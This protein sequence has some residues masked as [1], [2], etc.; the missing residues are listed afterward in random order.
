MTETNPIVD[1][2]EQTRRR[3][4]IVPREHGAWGLLLVPLFTGLVAGFSPEHRVWQLFLF[5]SATLSLFALRTPLESLLGIG[6]ISART[7]GERWTVFIAS[8]CFGLLALACLGVL[9]W[10]WQY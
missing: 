3:A 7:S 9:L 4:M 2:A 1:T 10:K 5:T 8:T 6:L